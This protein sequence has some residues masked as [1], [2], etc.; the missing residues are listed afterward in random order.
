MSSL[1][2]TALAIAVAAVV[3]PVSRP[4]EAQREH[5]DSV[6]LRN[7]CRLA[8][9]VLEHGQPA[10]KR[11]WAVRVL[12]LCGAT[13]AHWI[14]TSLRQHRADQVNTNALEEIVAATT[15]F[16]DAD[17]FAAAITLAQDGSAGTAARVQAVRII[18]YQITPGAA[19]PYEYFVSRQETN[20]AIDSDA[21]MTVGKPLPPNAPMTAT[22]TGHSIIADPLAPETVK[23]AARW[24]LR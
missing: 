1:F 11:P 20:L 6:E 22:A 7:W 16:K 14:T 5:A 18:Y 19:E 9:Q 24:L 15:I 23:R 8:E 3:L 4:L 2:K 12:P 13:A 10:N 17:V 21:P